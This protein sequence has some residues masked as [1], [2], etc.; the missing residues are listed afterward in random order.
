MTSPVPGI[1]PAAEGFPPALVQS[2]RKSSPNPKPLDPKPT[3]E[4]TLSA[5]SP[6]NSNQVR[7]MFGRIAPTYDLLNRLLS[8]R[9]DVAWRRRLVRS[10][11]ADAHSVLDLCTGTGDLV[12][13][14]D[15]ERRRGRD[16]NEKP[17]RAEVSRAGGREGRHHYEHVGTARLP[18]Q[19]AES[20][21]SVLHG[22]DFSF[23]MLA[24]GAAH[25]GLAERAH[26]TCADALHLPYR[27]GSFDAVLIAFG[28]R[29]FEDLETGISEIARVTRE[30]GQLLALEFFSGR[31]SA[32]EPL[33]R[34]YFE[35][36]LP[37]IGRIVSKDREAYT[38]L[39][40][41]VTRFPPG[42]AFRSLLETAGYEN[43]RIEP[44]TFGIVNLVVAERMS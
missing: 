28:L 12:L 20:S 8:L 1:E 26:L 16:T 18:D 21:A 42:P 24:W 39:P 35:R 9:R 7:A 11:R 43:I 40:T 2:P 23:P 33:F 41:S 13:E 22:S 3:L 27:D 25:K 29:N 31:R 6:K 38:Y 37:W 4:A 19:G 10:V 34:F 36:V 32:V 5:T 44:L 30:G 17:G 15:R 14:L